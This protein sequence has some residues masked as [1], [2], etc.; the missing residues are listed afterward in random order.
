MTPARTS[1]AANASAATTSAVAAAKAAYRVE[2]PPA[3]WPSDV[4]TSNEI[5]DVT[6]TEVWR[7]LQNAQKTNP[8]N[9]HA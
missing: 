4:P 2:S 6:V 5:A 3:S 1:H 7:E 8:E 9:R